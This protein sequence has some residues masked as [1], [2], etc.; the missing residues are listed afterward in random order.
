MLK[1]LKVIGALAYP[2]PAAAA[3]LAAKSGQS[4]PDAADADAAAPFTIFEY[5]RRLDALRE[6]NAERVAAARS[7]EHRRVLQ[8]DLRRAELALARDFERDGV[9]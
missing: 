7:M 3:Y 5:K 8:D 2:V 4:S 9:R 1:C 6:A